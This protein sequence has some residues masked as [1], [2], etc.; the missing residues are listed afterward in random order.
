MST[1]VLV[2]A[3]VDPDDAPLPTKVTDGVHGRLH[4]DEAAAAVAVDAEESGSFGVWRRKV[5]REV[6]TR[7]FKAVVVMMV[8]AMPEM[9][10]VVE[11]QSEQGIEG[12]WFFDESQEEH[13]EDSD[14]DGDEGKRNTG[15]EKELGFREQRF[16]GVH[17]YM[18][19]GC[20]C[21]LNSP[22]S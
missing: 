1:Y 3:V 9:E 22:V 10:I 17:I 16:E 14:G 5:R 20:M 19:G 15:H 13:G 12:R 4:R 18:I 6:V 2:D 8:L 7:R 21:V 11:I